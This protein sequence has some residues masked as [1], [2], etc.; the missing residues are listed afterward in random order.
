[1]P[2][3]IPLIGA[4][5]SVGAGIA[6]GATTLVG[7]LMI[8]GGAMTA[9]GAVTGN[10]KLQTIG[11]VL[12][13]VGGGIG[14][15][16]EL[17][18]AASLADTAS[19][20]A[21]A[22]D[23]ANMA[24][25][26]TSAANAADIGMMADVGMG[27]ADAAAQTASQA[28]QAAQVSQAAQPLL[29]EGLIRAA[30][31]EFGLDPSTLVNPTVNPPAPGAMESMAARS[32]EQAPSQ[33][34]QSPSAAA[35]PA[36]GPAAAPAAAPVASQSPGYGT[37][38]TENRGFYP[39]IQSQSQPTGWWDKATEAAGKVS[40]WM[41]KNPNTTKLASGIIGGAANYY[42]QMEAAEQQ[43]KNRLAY[44]DWARQRYSDSVR[45]IQVPRLIRQGTG[46]GGIIGGARG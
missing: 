24:D 34:V 23:I 4:A 43:Y 44:E 39:D 37:Y 1:M 17:A 28:A 9:V 32:V 36:A 11:S 45:N 22:S 19:S 27:A 12:G 21:S 6:A 29:D 46:T 15:F 5:F 33:F 13:L 3:A 35:T 18:S 7:G 2:A 42:G 41:K 20:V 38:A 40:G 26:G 8:A 30:Q 14:A 31:T 10:K 16:N 25:I